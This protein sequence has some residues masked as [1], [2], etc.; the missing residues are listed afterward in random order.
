MSGRPKHGKGKYAYQA[1]ISGKTQGQQAITTHLDNSG[2]A[3]VGEVRTNIVKHDIR[4]TSNMT[5]KMNAAAVIPASIGKVD[6]IFEMKRIAILAAAMLVI[7]VLL[8]IFIK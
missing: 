5:S 3:P 2:V 6:L 4:M 7:L 1:K 8:S